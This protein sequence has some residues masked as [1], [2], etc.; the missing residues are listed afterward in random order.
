M[1]EEAL[2]DQGEVVLSEEHDGFRWCEPRK[3]SALGV[4][5]AA[6][7]RG[8]ARVAARG[9]GLLLEEARASSTRP[10]LAEW[11][12]VRYSRPR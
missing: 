7:D 12:V 4:P 9:E 11:C 10:V 6:R 2:D 8:A 3:L 5:P 1:S